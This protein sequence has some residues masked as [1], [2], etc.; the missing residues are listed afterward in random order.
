MKLNYK[1]YG[2]GDK[3]IVLLHY[4]GGKGESWKW[5]AKRMEKKFRVVAITLPGFGNTDSLSQPSTYDFSEYINRCIAKLK[6]KNYVLC[7]HS[8]SGKLA[9]YAT[10]IN[11]AIKPKGVVLIAP[12]PPT[13]E[14]MPDKEKERML[15]HPNRDEAI[16]TVKNATVKS[17]RPRKFDLAVRTQLETDSATWSWWL[18]EGML[19]NI[20]DRIQGIDMPIFVICANK[21]PVISMD[22][23]YEDVLPNLHEPRLIQLGGCG[24]LIPLESPRKLSKRLRKIAKRVLD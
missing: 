13:I 16:K 3:T 11:A 23:I 21:D 10:Q 22:A 19:D 12:S 2:D 8:M 4:F 15:N 9:L 20:A 1:V 5:V 24:H 17:L 7:G 18:E 6:L 14:K